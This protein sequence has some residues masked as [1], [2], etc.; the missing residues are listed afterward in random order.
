MARHSVSVR[1]IS[2]VSADEAIVNLGKLMPA[3]V[4]DKKVRLFII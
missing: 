4:M 3:A 1:V 2:N